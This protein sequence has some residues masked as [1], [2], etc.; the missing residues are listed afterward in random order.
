VHTILIKDDEL[1][2]AQLETSFLHNKTYVVYER[3][4]RMGVLIDPSL[5]TPS[6]MHYVKKEQIPQSGMEISSRGSVGD[7]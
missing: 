2:I 7:V 1:I 6:I 5:F 4:T 3:S